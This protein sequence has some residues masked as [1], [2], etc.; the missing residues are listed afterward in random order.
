[1]AHGGRAPQS[2]RDFH[3]RSS[4]PLAI[5]CL[6]SSKFGGAGAPWCAAPLAS[7]LRPPRGAHVRRR[8]AWQSTPRPRQRKLR[9]ADRRRR[10]QPARRQRCPHWSCLPPWTI[11]SAEGLGRKGL[12]RGTRRRTTSAACASTIERAARRSSSRSSGVAP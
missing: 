6:A 3:L 12:S 10:W 11:F 8:V 5:S 2:R 9:G 7:I 4:L 1:E